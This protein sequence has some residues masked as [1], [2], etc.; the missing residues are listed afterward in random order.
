M[1][2]LDPSQ[3]QLAPCLYCRPNGI[4]P[5]EA[6]RNHEVDDQEKLA[7]ERQDNP[8]P[9]ALYTRYFESPYVR[10]R[11]LHRPQYERI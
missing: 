10:D 5:Q 9:Q 3:K 11:W 4:K 7:F 8:L 2:E 6:S 1:L